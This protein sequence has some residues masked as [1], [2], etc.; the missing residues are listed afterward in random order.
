MSY[1]GVMKSRVARCKAPKNVRT[2]RAPQILL[3][4]ARM[5]RGAKVGRQGSPQASMGFPCPKTLPCL[6]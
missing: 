2:Q 4:A 5:L 1:W 6:P 3:N